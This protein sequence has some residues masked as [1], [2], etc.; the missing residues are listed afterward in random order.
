MPSREAGLGVCLWARTCLPSVPSGLERRE[1][2]RRVGELSKQKEH[3][4][5]SGAQIGA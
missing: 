1:L 2:D 5:S 4:G 3:V